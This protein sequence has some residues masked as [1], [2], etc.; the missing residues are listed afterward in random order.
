MVCNHQ[1]SLGVQFIM[2]TSEE[3]EDKTWTQEKRFSVSQVI[4]NAVQ[5]GVNHSVLLFVNAIFL[6]LLLTIVLVI[7][8]STGLKL[9]M[10]LMII[11]A[12]ALFIGFNWFVA[13]V[14]QESS[15]DKKTK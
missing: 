8:F 9:Y 14:D 2:S 13:N 3:M 11:I 1:F 10:V 12:F 5:P 4:L 15:T 6:L 7:A